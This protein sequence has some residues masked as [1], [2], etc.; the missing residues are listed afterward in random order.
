MREYEL[1]LMLDTESP[2]ERRDE[3]ADSARA[4]IESAGTLRHAE[5]WGTR[6]MAFEIEKKTEADY[7]F[8]RFEGEKPLLDDLEHNLKITD[9]L[10]R[11]RI[12]KV[13]PDAPIVTPPMDSGPMPQRED[14]DERG[15]RGGRDDRDDRDSV[16]SAP[17]PAPSAPA[18]A[19]E[20]AAEQAA[21]ATEAP[22]ADADAPADDAAA[23]D[24]TT[25]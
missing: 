12:F 9:G 5:P 8:F 19:A 21:V 24:E 3:I 4:R 7:R 13:D 25:S 18:P 17:D 22:A 20:P 11:F 16:P 10:L 14:R 6:K 15:G 23:G 2:D 1:I